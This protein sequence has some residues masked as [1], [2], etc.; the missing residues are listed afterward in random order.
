MA[1]DHEHNFIAIDRS[2]HV[3]SL[4]SLGEREAK[5][6][7]AKKRKKRRHDESEDPELLEERS[8]QH[9]DFK[10]NCDDDHVDFKA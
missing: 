2:H 5:K 6:K 4:A 10:E 3:E 1:A 8:Q 7:Q 9:E